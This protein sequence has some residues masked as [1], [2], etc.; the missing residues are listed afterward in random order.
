MNNRLPIILTIIVIALGV[1]SFF[2]LSNRNQNKDYKAGSNEALKTAQDQ[3]LQ[4]STPEPEQLPDTTT[5]P[6]NSLDGRIEGVKAGAKF[7]FIKT[8]KTNSDGTTTISFDEAIMLNGEEAKLQATKDYGCT[9][10]KPTG[11]CEDD[12][13]GSIPND[14]YIQNNSTATVQYVLP[15]NVMLRLIDFQRELRFYKGTIDNLNQV[16]KENEDP[17]PPFWLNFDKNKQVMDVEQQYIP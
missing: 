4:E 16:L 11:P 10:S 3:S 7:G 1:A 6:M 12:G 14:F 8:V 2:I 9:T 5:G 17:Y 13:S 15:K